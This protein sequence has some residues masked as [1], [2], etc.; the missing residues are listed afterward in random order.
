[1]VPPFVNQTW[2]EALVS[3]ARLVAVMVT[4]SGR[5][6]APVSSACCAAV[7]PAA[8]TGAKPLLITTPAVVITGPIWT[9]YTGFV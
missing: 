2:Y 9:R 6:V 3:G 5:L 1:M 4:V 7:R 8:G